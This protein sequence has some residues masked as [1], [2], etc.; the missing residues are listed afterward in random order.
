MGYCGQFTSNFQTKSWSVRPQLTSGETHGQCAKVDIISEGPRLSSLQV[1][2]PSGASPLHENGTRSFC[3][4]LEG[5][6]RA[7]YAAFS[8]STSEKGASSSLLQAPAALGVRL[9]SISVCHRMVAT[10]WGDVTAARS[11]R[12]WSCS[13]LHMAPP[14][15]FWGGPV[16]RNLVARWKVV[17]S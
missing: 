16:V 13:I 12:I 9:G 7:R 17:R 15:R 8:H 3:P 5:L 6:E 10:L 4:D 14:S 2:H 11:F 1:S